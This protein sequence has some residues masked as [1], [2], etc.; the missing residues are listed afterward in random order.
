MVAET[1]RKHRGKISWT[2]A[3]LLTATLCGLMA[4]AAPPRRPIPK[5]RQLPV[6]PKLFEGNPPQHIGEY[7]SFRIVWQADPR[8]KDVSGVFPHPFHPQRIVAVTGAGLV[9]SDDT[10]NSWKELPG[11]GSQAIGAVR[12]VEF[13]PASADI[14]LAGEKGVWEIA[15][16]AKPP[17]QIGSKAKGLINDSVTQVRVDMGDPTYRTLVAVH[18]SDA[19][20]MSR[21]VDGGRTWKPIAG[22]ENYYIEKLFPG[23]PG[24]SWA[25][26]M[27]S[28]KDPSAA[29]GVYFCYAIGDFFKEYAP[30]IQANDCALELVFHKPFAE[31]SDLSYWAT[32]SSGILKTEHAG[33]DSERLGPEEGADKWTSIGV[34]WGANADRK[35]IYGYSPAKLGF[36]FSEDDGATFTAMSDGLPTGVFVR[37]GAQVRA[38]AGGSVF[39][40]AINGGLYVGRRYSGVLSITDIHVSPAFISYAPLHYTTAFNEF[41]AEVEAFRAHRPAASAAPAMLEK[42]RALRTFV[43]E[44]SFAI[45][46]RIGGTE[47]EKDMPARVTVDLSR[48]GGSAT[49]PMFD[50]G[51][52]ADGE[53]NDGVY[54][55]TC[56]LRPDRMRNLYQDPRRPTPGPMALT[57]TALAQDGSLSSGIGVIGMIER[58]ETHTYWSPTGREQYKDAEGG[59]S[60][61]LED[62]KS[63]AERRALKINTT[64]KAWS[65]PLSAYY[66]ANARGYSALSFFVKCDQASAGELYVQLK[67]F[68]ED[69]VAALTPRVPVVKEKLVEGGA[70]DGTYRRVV[71]PFSMLLKDE[72]AAAGTAKFRPSMLRSV[73]VSG[74]AGKPR[75]YWITAIRFHVNGDEK[76]PA[77]SKEGAE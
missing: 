28:L 23:G 13:A 50:D 38:N 9:I 25:F 36:A 46:A 45:T 42:T 17:V 72:D 3:A 60:G 62:P 43:S 37:Q 55:T 53:A 47:D 2:A 19:G 67:D 14:Y 70:I 40:G 58:P 57:I 39:F 27:A 5:K 41:R 52:H 21:S 32:A 76:N 44:P 20:G 61:S 24:V 29:R 8:L 34:T 74:D 65:M 75:H 56:M 33:T 10:G 49:A 18:G 73:V 77:S 64:D 12:H 22:F 54:G 66:E 30:E 26:A 35:L 1:L 69:T 63:G 6:D 59:I 31:V 7:P 48:V 4:E 11:T 51:Q 16:I 71:V 68:S 15:D